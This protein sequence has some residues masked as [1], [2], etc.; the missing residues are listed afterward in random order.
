MGPQRAAVE[1]RHRQAVAQRRIDSLRRAAGNFTCCTRKQPAGG[2]IVAASGLTRDPLSQFHRDVG[3]TEARSWQTLTRWWSWST[4]R[5]AGDGVRFAG[6]RRL[7][8][9]VCRSRRDGVRCGNAGV[10]V[11]GQS[12]CAPCRGSNTPDS[13]VRCD[14]CGSAATD[15]GIEDWAAVGRWHMVCP[16]CVPAIGAL[17]VGQFCDNYN[18]PA[19]RVTADGSNACLACMDTFSQQRVWLARAQELVTRAQRR[20]S[21]NS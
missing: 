11:M 17:P 5:T 9:G 14:C 6:L 7:T 4:E 3:R 8:A 21:I 16:Q 1:E 19:T 18:E 12:L 20:M 2:D 10:L 13:L 15:S